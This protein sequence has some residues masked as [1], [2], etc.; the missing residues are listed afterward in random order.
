M[1]RAFVV[2]RLSAAF[3]WLLRH[4]L[5]VFIVVSGIVSVVALVVAFWIE[6]ALDRWKP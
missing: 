2:H 6:D 3:V 1:G 5:L 4:S